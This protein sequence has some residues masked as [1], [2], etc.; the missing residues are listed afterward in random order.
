MSY[1]HEEVYSG[2]IRAL[3]SL[4]MHTERTERGLDVVMRPGIHMSHIVP[5][6]R[7]VFNAY[8]RK[9]FVKYWKGRRLLRVEEGHQRAQRKSPRRTQLPYLEAGSQFSPQ[10]EAP[11]PQQ[12]ADDSGT[13]FFVSEK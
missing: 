4:L 7:D 9:A 8:N 10:A 6:I 5:A 11:A 2:I 1:P 3:G 12:L 13:D